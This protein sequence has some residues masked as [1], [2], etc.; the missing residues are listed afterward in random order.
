MSVKNT[1]QTITSILESFRKDFNKTAEEAAPVEEKQEDSGCVACETKE[2]SAEEAPA[3]VADATDSLKKMADEYIANH[4]EALKKEAA[5]F[6]SIFADAFASHMAEKGA[7]EALAKTAEEEAEYNNL[8]NVLFMDK[9]ASIYDEAYLNTLYAVAGSVEEALT[10]KLASVSAEA[11]DTT[12]AKIAGVSEAVEAAAEAVQDVAAAARAVAE[13][14]ADED[15][16]EL[17]DL[18]TVSPEA[19]QTMLGMADDGDAGEEVTPVEPTPEELR[20]IQD[21]AYANV[22]AQLQGQGA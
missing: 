19:Y 16:G 4:D 2:A 10:E 5:I 14:G 8:F 1:N 3:E 11:Y 9:I 20:G 6:G 21:E 15:D 17:G 18:T 13:S 12:M 7:E 22:L